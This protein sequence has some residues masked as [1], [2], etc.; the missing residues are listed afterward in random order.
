VSGRSAG[1]TSTVWAVRRPER[2]SS[3]VD[4]PLERA[5]LNVLDGRDAERTHDRSSRSRH[6]ASAQIT[7][8]WERPLAW[9]RWYP[10]R[11]AFPCPCESRT[12]TWGVDTASRAATLGRELS[13]SS[14]WAF[15]LEGDE[16]GRYRET[17]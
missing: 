4:P 7:L 11:V 9:E 1:G 2:I 13:G 14:R 12:S 16:R 3:R 8:R 15:V 6:R 17:G 5:G 10:G